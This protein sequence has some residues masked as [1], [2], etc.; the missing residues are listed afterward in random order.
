MSTNDR[1]RIEAA[2]DAGKLFVRMRNGNFWQA[3]RNGKTQLWK[4]R[5]D[6]FRIPAKAGLR[7]TFQITEA[8]LSTFGIHFEIRD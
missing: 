2:L 1:S 4:T 7:T 8:D 5:P 6:D 3:R